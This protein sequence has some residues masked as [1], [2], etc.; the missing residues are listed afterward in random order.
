MPQLAPV[1][2]SAAADG[3][4]TDEILSITAKAAMA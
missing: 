4:P 2:A 1:G 3:A